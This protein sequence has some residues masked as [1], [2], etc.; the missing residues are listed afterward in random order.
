ME[1]HG[2]TKIIRLSGGKVRVM[3]DL[4]KSEVKAFTHEP[5]QCHLLLDFRNIVHITS[6][7]LVVLIN[8]YKRMQSFGGELILSNL[9]EDVYGVFVVTRLH[10]LLTVSRAGRGDS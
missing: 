7:D 6:D 3:E 8:L 9:N 4:M 2:N 1:Q 10:T 5:R